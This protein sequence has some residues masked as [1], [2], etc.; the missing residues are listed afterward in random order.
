[1]EA[2]L[3]V[4]AIP[5]G[6][7]GGALSF[8]MTPVDFVASFIL[9][10][11][12]DI[13]NSS[14]TTY[15]L[16]QPKRLSLSRFAKACE[17]A[18]YEPLST[19]SVNEWLEL[20]A[21]K[22]QAGDCKWVGKDTLI[23]ICREGDVY[24]TANVGECYP[25]VD[26]AAMSHLVVK[27][28]HEWQH[29]P[30]VQNGAKQLGLEDK[31]VM[32]CGAGTPAGNEVA[33]RLADE[34]AQLLLVGLDQK[35]T[36]LLG[37]DLGDDNSFVAPEGSCTELATLQAAIHE[38]EERFGKRVWGLVNCPLISEK[39]GSDTVSWH[40]HFEAGC[41]FV[42]NA[43]TAA[44]PSLTHTDEGDNQAQQRG[45]VIN[46][47]EDPSA[48]KP[49]LSGI[50]ASKAFLDA[51]T[52]GMKAQLSP[53]GVTVVTVSLARQSGELNLLDSQAQARGVADSVHNTLMTQSLLTSS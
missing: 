40:T 49:L 15:H 33:R 20:V 46:V 14:G 23:S 28:S 1:M 5:S 29:L 36:Q 11:A 18:G 44:L 16:I 53:L 47:S 7:E 30:G 9:Q 42:M 52:A 6:V 26:E 41:K 25:A 51:W 38:A 32:V 39:E 37:S 8:E 50:S 13:R 31:L 34:G 21:T 17:M 45:F 4:G 10:C 3:S 12:D 48:P 27:L 43:T 2:C 24:D 22:A 19:V 35:L